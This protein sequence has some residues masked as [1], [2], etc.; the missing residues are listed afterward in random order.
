MS[1]EPVP[2]AGSPRGP[3]HVAASRG[4]EVI[5][6]IVAVVSGAGMAVQ[7]RVNSELGA[8]TGDP[9][10]ASL[11]SFGTGL[12]IVIALAVALPAGRRG[13]LA[14]IRAIRGRHVPVWFLIS[15]FFGA[16]LVLVQTFTTP[17]VGVAVFILGIVVGQALGGL[18]VDRVGLGPGGFK[19]LTVWRLVGTG[20][21]V[22]AVV[23]AE[24][25]RFAQE[26]GQTGTVGTWLL[27]VVVALQVLAGAGV[28]MQTAL[29]GRMAQRAGTPIT[30]TL[31]NFTG[32]TLIL[33]LITVVY[34]SVTD[35][36]AWHFPTDWWLYLG[37]V[38]GLL[39]VAA[40]AVL[41]RIIGVLRTSLSLTAGMLT[42]ALILDLAVPTT[43]SLVTPLTVAG[44][45]LTF[46]G[47]VLVTLPWNR[48]VRTAPR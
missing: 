1:P 39:F 8:R 43:G 45:V 14:L 16:C 2:G 18:W 36:P 19:P 24:I 20:V 9:T 13:M 28:A 25:P 10:A 11:I 31:V 21:I 12:V 37:G 6:Q 30:S 4:V 32:G 40:G 42:G 15:G 38:V 35:L 5:A 33:T 46:L 7:S 22:G 41:A 26:T 29:N 23:I 3:E 47:L 17:L 27:V 44:I 48:K 34:R